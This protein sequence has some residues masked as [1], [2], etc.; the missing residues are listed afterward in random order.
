[1]NTKQE[2]QQHLIE[3]AMKDPD[4]RKRLLENPRTVIEEETGAKIPDGLNIKVMEEDRSTIYLV[5]PFNYTGSNDTE[6]SEADLEMVSGAVGPWTFEGTPC[7]E[8]NVN[9]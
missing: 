6:L 4:F 8:V 3:K 1:M 5:L 9:N 7:T 2:F